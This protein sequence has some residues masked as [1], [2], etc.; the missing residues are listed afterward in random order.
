LLDFLL[1]LSILGERAHLLK[2]QLGST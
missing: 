1:F 2:T